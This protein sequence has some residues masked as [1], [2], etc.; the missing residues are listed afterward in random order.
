MEQN[1]SPDY[2]PY[3]PTTSAEEIAEKKRVEDEKIDRYF[4]DSMIETPLNIQD[5]T[6]VEK[7]VF[8]HRER[9]NHTEDDHCF[10]FSE[11]NRENPKFFLLIPMLDSNIPRGT[12]E[13]VFTSI[14]LS[15]IT[16][17][18]L[19]S[20]CMRQKE[21]VEDIDSK[22]DPNKINVSEMGTNLMIQGEKFYFHYIPKGIGANGLDALREVK[23]K[24][25]I[26]NTQRDNSV[27]NYN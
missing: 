5:S 11:E 24:I 18:E 8:I 22:G 12:F 2:A 15:L 4:W 19:K 9:E 21:I 6:G 10:V 26:R 1:L 3:W 27:N 16:E 13:K 17:E 14:K 7:T 25:G 20:L 23:R